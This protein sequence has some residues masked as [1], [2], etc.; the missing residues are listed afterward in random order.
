MGIFSPHSPPP[1]SLQ[2][3]KYFEDCLKKSGEI[4]VAFSLSAFHVVHMFLYGG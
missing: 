1:Q 4:Q 2:Y 3:S